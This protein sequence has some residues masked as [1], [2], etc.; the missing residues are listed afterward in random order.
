M[1]T[2]QRPK[3]FQ[4]NFLLLS[5]INRLSTD[6][7]LPDFADDVPYQADVQAIWTVNGLLI[8]FPSDI[9]VSLGPTWFRFEVMTKII[10]RS[11]VRCARRPNCGRDRIDPKLVRT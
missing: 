11:I 7:F 10:L 3:F 8:P 9:L 1:P 2:I 5:G 4:L 6:L